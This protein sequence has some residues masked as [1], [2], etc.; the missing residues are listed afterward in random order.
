MASNKRQVVHASAFMQQHTGPLPMADEFVRYN[1][2]C[3]GAAERIL[4]MAENQAAHRQKQEKKVVTS[5]CIN[6]FLGVVSAFIIS[7]SALYF[8]YKLISEGHNTAGSIFALSGLGAT[9]GAFIY[10]TR[11]N[12][13]IR[14]QQK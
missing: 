3:A 12:K 5:Q 8:G 7:M 4:V 11:A 9:V 14:Q 13:Q 10:G 1:D 2:G 6:S